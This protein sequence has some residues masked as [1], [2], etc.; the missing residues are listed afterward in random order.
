MPEKTPRPYIGLPTEVEEA[1]ECE[2]YQKTSPNNIKT[3]Q[4]PKT[5]QEQNPK[6]EPLPDSNKKQK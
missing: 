5:D 6:I 4:T 2:Y 3:T 1:E